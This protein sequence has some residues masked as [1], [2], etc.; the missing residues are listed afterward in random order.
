MRFWTLWDFPPKGRRWETRQETNMN[1]TVVKEY[2]AHLD[3]K[4]RITLRGSASEY[5]AVKVLDNGSVIL[6]PRVL[7]PPNAISK[8]S[9]RMLDRSAKNFKAGKVSAPI[10]LSQYR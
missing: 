4:K 10:D 7:V 3:A 2:D 8:R 6:E 1:T 5:Y 9:L